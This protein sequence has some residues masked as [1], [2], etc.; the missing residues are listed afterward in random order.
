[1]SRRSLV[2]SLATLV[3]LREREVDRLAADMA[4][5]E[6]VRRRYCE[7]IERLRG[8]CTGESAPAS[9]PMALSLNLAG[10]KQAVLRMVEQH[11]EDL[12]LHEADMA[13]TQRALAAASQRREVLGQVLRREQH[14][15]RAEQGVREQKRQDEL[16]SQVWW[17]S[18]R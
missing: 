13:V 9:L 6:A 5:K 17:R 4:S 15:L 1:V 2:T 16:A 3:D 12:A 18:E 8:M 7:S 14:V 10:Y 11:R